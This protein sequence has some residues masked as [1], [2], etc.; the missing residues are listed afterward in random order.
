[1]S[2]E[3]PVARFCTCCSLLCETGSEGDN[4]GASF[5]SRRNRELDAI[6]I[7][8]EHRDTLSSLS[9]WESTLDE[10]KSQLANTTDLLVTGRL[11]SI[12]TSRGALRIA[13]RHQA[14][15]D[16][17]E[18]DAAFEG[19]TAFQRVGA[20][21]VSLAEARDISELLIVV[22]GDPL[23][24]DY[25]RLPAALAR[26]VSIPV[27]LLGSWSHAGCKPWL[28]AG[29]D[30]LAIDTQISNIPRSLSEAS[31]YASVAGWESQASQWLHR[32]GYATVLWSMKHLNIEHGDLWYESMMG[33]VARENETRRVGALVWSD[34]ESTFHQVCTWWT[35]FP[36]RIRFGEVRFGE[37]SVQYDPSRFT[38]L[39]WL[40][41]HP[42][43]QLTSSSSL[44]LWID[45]SF[46]DLPTAL[47]ESGHRCIAI[48]ARAPRSDTSVLWLPSLP[49]GL[50]CESELFRGDNA[51]LVQG[52][53]PYPIAHEL[54]P[55]AQWL[56]GLIE[57]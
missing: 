49:A 53:D 16:T 51:I 22:G 8:S 6:R 50:G 43:K 39:R 46:E 9:T 34:L 12:D 11:R 5:C 35:G 7:W 26:G 52:Q 57:T 48:S 55:T 18:S 56:R 21:T 54:P 1:M 41:S 33:W 27:L 3:L 19:I 36:G 32:S 31:T 44:I 17:W 42:I 28:D 20:A 4:F 14:V 30:V 23:M 40:D 15:V 38:A 10:A 29:F 2:T 37:D 25:P 13:Q 45:D 47:F 24:E